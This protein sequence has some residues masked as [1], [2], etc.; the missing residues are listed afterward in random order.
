MEVPQE[1]K[2]PGVTLQVPLVLRM[3]PYLPRSICPTCIGPYVHLAAVCPHRAG[4]VPVTV[5]QQHSTLPI[6]TPRPLGLE[7][8]HPTGMG[9]EPARFLPPSLLPVDW[10]N[11]TATSM[12]GGDPTK[13]TQGWGGEGSNVF[14]PLNFLTSASSQVSK[15]YFKQILSSNEPEY[16]CQPSFEREYPISRNASHLDVQFVLLI[17]LQTITRA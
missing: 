12:L 2:L 8:K 4:A 13:C 7:E 10:E 6:R 9:A 5:D 15:D 11:P 14:K 16:I 1:A 3:T 17:W